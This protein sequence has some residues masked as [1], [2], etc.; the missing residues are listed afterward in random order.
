MACLEQKAATSPG[1]M[2]RIAMLETLA[3]THMMPGKNPPWSVATKRRGYPWMK[4]RQRSDHAG[5]PHIMTFP[6]LERFGRR[7]GVKRGYSVYRENRKLRA[8][9]IAVASDQW[10]AS[11]F[12]KLS[13]RCWAR[14]ATARS[15]G[16]FFFTHHV[17]YSL[18]QGE[19]RAIA[20]YSVIASRSW[21]PGGRWRHLYHH[22]SLFG[23]VLTLTLYTQHCS[24]H[25]TERAPRR[26]LACSWVQQHLISCSKESR[27][28]NKLKTVQWML[29]TMCFK[30]AA[31]GASWSETQAFIPRP[32]WWRRTW[33]VPFLKFWL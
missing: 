21:T 32:L 25:G 33:K 7:E 23:Q 31:S 1:A 30:G 13:T 14:S 24:P 16:V 26:L 6:Y 9:L 2:L 12:L 28:T 15:F 20:H 5:A 4:F 11:S 8:Q 17:G 29:F 18:L 3:A 19:Q 10:N 22:H 27:M